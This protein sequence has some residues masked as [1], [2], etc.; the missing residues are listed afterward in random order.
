MRYAWI[1]EEPF[2]RA[3][4]MEGEHIQTDLELLLIIRHHLCLEGETQT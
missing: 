3:Q 1:L 2:F 4:V